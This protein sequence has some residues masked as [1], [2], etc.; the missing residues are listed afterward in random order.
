[1]NCDDNDNKNA[2]DNNNNNNNNINNRVII[3]FLFINMLSQRPN[4]Q[5]KKWHKK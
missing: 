1:M 3:K 4:G 2:D 5:F